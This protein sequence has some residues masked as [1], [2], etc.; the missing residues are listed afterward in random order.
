MN[1]TELKRKV[2]GDTYHVPSI[3]ATQIYGGRKEQKMT[4]EAVYGWGRKHWR[5]KR[6]VRAKKNRAAN[7]IPLSPLE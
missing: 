1:E 4:E 5:K 7:I 6:T 2:E 3:P